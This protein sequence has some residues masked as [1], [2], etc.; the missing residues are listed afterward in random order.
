M[1]EQEYEEWKADPQAQREYE[2][3]RIEDE[4]KRA[5]LPD[6]FT[7]EPQSF[8]NAFNSIFKK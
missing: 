1:N 3:W 2:Q 8:I 4:L 7:T 5:Q 6:P